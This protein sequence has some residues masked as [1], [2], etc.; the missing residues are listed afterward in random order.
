MP[1]LTMDDVQWVTQAH[2]ND[3]TP[4]FRP[5]VKLNG[6]KVE[7]MGTLEWALFVRPPEDH[8]WPPTIPHPHNSRSFYFYQLQS[9]YPKRHKLCGMCHQ[10]R[11]AKCRGSCKLLQARDRIQQNHQFRLAMPSRTSISFSQITMDDP[12]VYHAL[13]DA[14]RHLERSRTRRR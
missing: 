6:I 5:P 14:Q 8:K 2:F 1:L 11:P 7:D 10:P 12:T 9:A 3:P 13:D 4:P